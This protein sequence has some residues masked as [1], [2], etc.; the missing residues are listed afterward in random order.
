MNK[1]TKKKGKTA[2]LSKA[3]LPRF[4]KATKDSKTSLLRSKARTRRKRLTK[5]FAFTLIALFAGLVVGAIT[6]VF[7]PAERL[8]GL[9]GG[10]ALREQN[11]L[12]LGVDFNYDTSGKQLSTASSA[13]NQRTDTILLAHLD[14]QNRLLNVISLPRDTRALIPGYGIGKLNLAHALKGPK[15]AIE[16]VES[17]LDVKID[18]FI[19]IDLG[20]AKNLLDI[21]GGL[22]IFVEAPM[23]YTDNTANLKIDLK[24]G[25]QRLSGQDAV[26][27]ARFRHDALGDIGR[28]HR[29][30]MLINAVQQKLCN[31]LN[32]WRLPRLI[33]AGFASVTTDMDAQQI[34][35]ILHFVKNRD[36]LSTHF[37]TLPGDFGYDGFWLPNAGRIASLHD[38]LFSQ[39]KNEQTECRAELLFAPE[40]AGRIDGLIQSLDQAG[41]QVVHSHPMEGES[42]QSTR[43]LSN[44]HNPNWEKKIKSVLPSAPCQLS[45]DPSNYS[46][47]FTI[48]LG[49]DYR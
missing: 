35:Q 20:K 28:V 13:Q 19:R 10:S 15:G 45:D 12:L 14:P 42:R 24:P 6:K 29:Q 11:V 39:V 2:N 33:S 44:G 1:P 40:Q 48:V 43:I 41:I 7:I 30:Q 25:W 36:N 38:A 5:L 34:G 27:F 16:T 4:P 21:V 31:P 26:S 32:W 37:T 18:H 46:A 47:D 8:S 3:D 22:D 49:A 9:F 23:Q 17:L